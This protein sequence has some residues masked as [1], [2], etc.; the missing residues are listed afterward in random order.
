MLLS[1]FLYVLV[2]VL[3]LLLL[4]RHKAAPSRHRY[5]KIEMLAYMPKTLSLPKDWSPLSSLPPTVVRSKDHQLRVKSLSKGHCL[6]LPSTDE[7]DYDHSFDSSWSGT[8]RRSRDSPSC[9]KD[10]REENRRLVTSVLAASEYS[11]AISESFDKLKDM[12]VIIDLRTYEVLL[13]TAIDGEDLAFT[14]RLLS[15]ISG[16]GFALKSSLVEAYLTLFN[17]KN[18]LNRESP[19]L[20]ADAQEFKPETSLNPFA[21]DFVPVETF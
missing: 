18:G 10:A 9:D 12:N 19:D 8:L 13:K 4:K 3:A 21:A 15:E 14:N 2:A 20:R 16:H 17:R 11:P 5:S 1:A 7:S 6:R